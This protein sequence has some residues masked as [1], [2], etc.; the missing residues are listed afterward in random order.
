[1]ISQSAFEFCFILLLICISNRSNYVETLPSTVLQDE[2]Q[3]QQEQ[4]EAISENFFDEVRQL[5]EQKIMHSSETAAALDIDVT[6]SESP[7]IVNAEEHTIE[8]TISSSAIET[9]RKEIASTIKSPKPTQVTDW[10][11]LD[12]RL[13]QVVAVSIGLDGHPVIFHRADRIWTDE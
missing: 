1:M 9:A 12:L 10:P 13:G 2:Q 11:K 6:T 3:Q 5:L 4:A 8:T 7:P